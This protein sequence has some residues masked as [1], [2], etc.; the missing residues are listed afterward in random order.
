MAATSILQWVPTLEHEVIDIILSYD[1]RNHQQPTNNWS[2][3]VQVPKWLPE[4]D[5]LPI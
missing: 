4:W 1:D 2:N 5:S 3:Y